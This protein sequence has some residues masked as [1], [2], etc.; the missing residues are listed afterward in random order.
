MPVV[1]EPESMVCLVALM[2]C[3]Q[4]QHPDGCTFTQLMLFLS[5]MKT[6]IYARAGGAQDWT[7][8]QE[9]PGGADRKMGSGA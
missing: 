7:D 3:K 2:T 1:L 6:R 9:G 5:W 4:R 8:A